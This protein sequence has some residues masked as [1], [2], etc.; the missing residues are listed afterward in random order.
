MSKLTTGQRNSLSEKAFA[1][2]G[3]KFPIEDRAHQ[4]A[5]LKLVGRSLK[6]GNITP[7][8]AATVK[9]KARAKLGKG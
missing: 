3:R 6:A 5:A 2:P 9:R 8:Q 7:A 4:E 1:L